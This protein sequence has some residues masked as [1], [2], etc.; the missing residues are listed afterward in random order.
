MICLK[1]LNK[2]ASIF[3]FIGNVIEIVP[4]GDGHINDTYLVRTDCNKYIL[5]RIN[6]YVFKEPKLVMRNIKYVTQ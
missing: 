5:Q 1:K 6:S 2:I 3:N 4:Y